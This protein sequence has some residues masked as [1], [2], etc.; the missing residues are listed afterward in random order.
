MTIPVSGLH[1]LTIRVNDMER[2]RS[3]YSDTLG[4]DVQTPT[5]DLYFFPVG[6]NYPGS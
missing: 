3:F 5:P 2:S 4:F 1:H 6:Q